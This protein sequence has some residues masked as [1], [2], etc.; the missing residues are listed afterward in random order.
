MSE[1][2]LDMLA[3]PDVGAKV[4]GLYKL[5]WMD[6]AAITPEVIEAAKRLVSDPDKFVRQTAA[7]VLVYVGGSDVVAWL[8]DEHEDRDV[9]RAVAEAIAEV[10][11]PADPHV[12][13]ALLRVV[14]A[15]GLAANEAAWAYMRTAPSRAE[16]ALVLAQVG[17]WAAIQAVR[18]AAKEFG[19]ELASQELVS[20]LAQ[21]LV[22]EDKDPDFCLLTAEAL[23][24]LA[25]WAATPEV[26][27]AMI[28]A[29]RRCCR[30]N[31]SYVTM[32]VYLKSVVVQAGRRVLV[33]AL[34]VF[35]EA[36]REAEVSTAAARLAGQEPLWVDAQIPE[37][38][39][40][41][42]E[43]VEDGYEREDSH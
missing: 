17:N 22:S 40:W 33:D 3:S 18:R 1:N 15:G 2:I 28:V 26:I 20:A 43:S 25:R 42:I 37:I 10:G 39:R 14:R 19:Q 11:A 16:A 35:E 38:A 6:R 4:V 23:A 34:E 29:T 31:D 9:W 24:R 8:L 12:R 5:P 21:A 30:L 41:A 27:R 7:R 36:I 32:F 13:F